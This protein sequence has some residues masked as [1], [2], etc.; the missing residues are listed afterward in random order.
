[1]F[2]ESQAGAAEMRRDASYAQIPSM[3]TDMPPATNLQC[4]MLEMPTNF[5]CT[6]F[7]YALLERIPPELLH[8]IAFHL[9]TT[10][11]TLG[12]P[13]SIL[14]LL[15]T[16]RKIYAMLAPALPLLAAHV[17]HVRFDADALHRRFGTH[18]VN[19]PVVM[20]GAMRERYETLA[21]IRRA[22][23]EL[24][25]NTKLTTDL[26]TAYMML[27]EHDCMN[28]AQLLQYAALPRFLWNLIHARGRRGLWY[29]RTQEN[30][31]VMSLV[32]WLLWLTTTAGKW[33]IATD[34]VAWFLS[35]CP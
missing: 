8:T 34:F 18:Q 10:L 20:A 6:H 35:L 22:D 11:T 32:C 5:H 7:S 12:P 30:I 2:D 23:E 25:Q 19:I 27:L 14:A 3:V 9:L 17:F 24:E 4:P 1:M 16:S 15:L 21:R 33:A 26:W 31:E 13:A 28:R 29:A